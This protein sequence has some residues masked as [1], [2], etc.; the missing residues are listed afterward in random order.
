MHV[1]GLPRMQG[2]DVRD[3][4]GAKAADPNVGGAGRFYWSNRP[5][6]CASMV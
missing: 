1:F 4:V 3:V 5:A 6:A 2:Q